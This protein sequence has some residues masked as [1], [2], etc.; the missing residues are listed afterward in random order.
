MKY[1]QGIVETGTL[2]LLT[3]ILTTIEAYQSFAEASDQ[4]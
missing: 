3:H 4:V 1:C 2:S